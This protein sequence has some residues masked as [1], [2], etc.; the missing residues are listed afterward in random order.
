M[1]HK[2]RVIGY[3]VVFIII[4]ILSSLV[5][6][7][8]GIEKFSSPTYLRGLL[9]SV[10]AWG[11]LVYIILLILSVP[12]PIPSAPIVLTGGYVY[13]AFLGTVLSLLANTI[14][15]TIGF[16]LI[17]KNGKPLLEKLVDKHHILHFNH[18]FKKRGEVVA[19]ISYIVPIFPSDAVSMLLGLSKIRYHT[20]FILLILGHIPRYVL[21]ST[22]GNDLFTGFTPLTV[23]VLIGMILLILIALFREKLK[24]FF[25][26]EL[27]EIESEVKKVEEEIHLGK[28]SKK[29]NNKIRKKR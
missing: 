28:K 20:F 11:Y 5:Y 4:I 9:L 21:I 19:F 29:R 2:H 22:F 17:R 3:I 10:G 24:R 13:G 12:L 1:K 23:A 15:A 8:P 18:L 25:F 7:I 16:Y 6:F 26:K 27:H 14:G